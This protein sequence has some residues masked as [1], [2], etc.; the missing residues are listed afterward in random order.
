MLSS[1]KGLPV[2]PP[3]P[4]QRVGDI[5]RWLSQ[6]PKLAKRQSQ[7]AKVKRILFIFIR[8]ETVFAAATHSFTSGF[9]CLGMAHMASTGYKGLGHPIWHLQ[10]FVEAAGQEEGHWGELLSRPGTSLP[11]NINFQNSVTANFYF[12]SPFV[13]KQKNISKQNS[14]K[15]I[16]ILLKKKKNH[17]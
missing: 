4:P 3:C 5:A 2:I 9:H 13:I 17:P 11:Q 6:F 1:T 14:S 16:Q 15:H 7:K 10:P 12:L 8:E